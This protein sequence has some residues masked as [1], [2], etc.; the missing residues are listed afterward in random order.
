MQIVL[1]QANRLHDIVD[2]LLS[3]S[4][5]EQEEE[6]NEIELQPGQLA[7][8]LQNCIEAGA[9]KAKEK[10]LAL[11]L[12][13]DGTISV[14]MNARLLEQAVTNLLINAIKYSQERGEIRIAANQEGERW[15]FA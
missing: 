14:R 13:C 1:K 2:D 7:P 10:D 9:M 6:H 3:L 5:I 12:H 8:V 15:S 11:I 4:R